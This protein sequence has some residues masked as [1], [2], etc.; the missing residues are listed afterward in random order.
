VKSIALLAAGLIATAGHLQ[1]QT[2]DSVKVGEVVAGFHAALAAGDSTTALS[3]L[4]EGLRVLE[5]GGLET[6][7]EYRAHHLPADMTFAQALPSE[8]T[9][10]QITVRG[11][12]AWVVSTSRTTGTYRERPVNS[13]GAE[14]VVLAREGG[15]WRIQAIHWSSRAIRAP[16]SGG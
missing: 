9:V 5:S 15:A 2:T 16:Q 1:A 11:D 14:L 4:S 3:F 7:S 6:R 12:V 10:D 8:R 13:A